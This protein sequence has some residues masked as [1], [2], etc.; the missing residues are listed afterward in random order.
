MLGMLVILCPTE[1]KKKKILETVP[2]GIN[3]SWQ[4]IEILELVLELAKTP[5]A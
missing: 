3:R 5:S 1:L 4:L 2:Q